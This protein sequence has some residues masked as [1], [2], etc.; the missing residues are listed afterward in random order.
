MNEKLLEYRK[1]EIDSLIAKRLIRH[2]KSSWSC[3][4][5]YVQMQ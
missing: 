3:G 4:A 1:Q 5:F 2:S